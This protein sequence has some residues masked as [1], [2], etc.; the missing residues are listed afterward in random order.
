MHDQADQL[1]KLVRATIH[2]D[3]ALAP[4]GPIIA[5]SGGQKQVGV[6]AIA[7]GLARELARLGK[8]VVLI[9]ANLQNPSSARALHSQALTP[10]SAP[11]NSPDLARSGLGATLDE[12]LSGK[13]RATEVL[14]STTESNLRVLPGVPRNSTPELDRHALDRFAAELSALSRDVDLILLDCGHGMNAW[15]DRLWQLARD[16]LLVATP[17]P[18]CILDAYAA[19]KLS[20]HQRLH[21]KLRLLINRTLDQAEVP[22]LAARFDATCQRFLFVTPKPAWS[23]PAITRNNEPFER[24]LRLLAADIAC[25][26][27]VSALRLIQP[28]S[29]RAPATHS[30]ES[31]EI[32]RRGAEAQRK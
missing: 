2:A 14:L 6:T 5:V 11:P 31:K 8:Q 29:R 15:I 16:V 23:L 20:Q 4:G 18:Q 32:S 17:A 9:D 26:L 27:R 24:A 19:V 13:R 25:D 3:P 28:S 22:P 21:N 30:S 12:V 10:S 7:C 1:R